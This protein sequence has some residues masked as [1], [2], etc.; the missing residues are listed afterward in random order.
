MAVFQ[1]MY[2]L[3]KL[4]M[5]HVPNIDCFHKNIHLILIGSIFS[6]KLPNPENYSNEGNIFKPIA[7]ALSKAA[8][9]MLFKEAC[10]TLSSEKLR[11]NMVTLGGVYTGQNNFF[12]EKYT[13]K[14]PMKKMVNLKDIED[15]LNWII[16]KSPQIVNGCEF[17]VDGGWT[18]AN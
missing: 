6:R 4:T 10:R 14:V 13:S 18:L 8:Q 16:F 5:N 9:N 12:V 11:I 7:Y 15:C 3:L 2:Y 17:L 1:H